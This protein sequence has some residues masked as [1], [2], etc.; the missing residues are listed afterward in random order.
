MKHIKHE[1]YRDEIT[2]AMAADLVAAGT[3]IEFEDPAAAAE[4]LIGIGYRPTAVS[5]R[6]DFAIE[7]ALYRP[8]RAAGAVSEFAAM[9]IAAGVWLAWYVALCPAVTA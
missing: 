7:Q 9:T 1:Q 8:Y 3:S 4:Y 6:I 5:H 2:D